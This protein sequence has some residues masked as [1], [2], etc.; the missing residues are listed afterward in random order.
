MSQ[1]NVGL[2]R[3]AHERLNEGTSTVGSVA[4]EGY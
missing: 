3:L 1:E 4:G 2:I